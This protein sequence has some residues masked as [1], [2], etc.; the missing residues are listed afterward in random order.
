M[1]RHI[2]FTVLVVCFYLFTLCFCSQNEDDDDDDNGDNDVTD[3]DVA[4][5]DSA[6]DDLTDDDAVDDDT[7]DDDDSVLNNDLVWG[8]CICGD[9]DDHTLVRVGSYNLHGGNEASIEEL[10][11]GIANHLPFDLLFLQECPEDYSDGLAA[12]LGM[13]SFRYGGLAILWKRAGVWRKRTLQSTASSSLFM[14]CTW[15]GIP[16]VT[17]SAANLS[18]R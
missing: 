12:E 10:A 6:D 11:Q 2:W 1:N 9:V 15:A 8:R 14:R 18:T 4:D 13:N 3:D 7:T 17:H 5:D 16:R